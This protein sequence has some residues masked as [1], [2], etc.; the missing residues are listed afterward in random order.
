MQDILQETQFKHVERTIG[1]MLA[2]LQT[3]SRDTKE[4]L[5]SGESMEVSHFVCSIMGLCI[6]VL[7]S[8][9]QF[10]LHLKPVHILFSK[11]QYNQQ[12]KLPGSRLKHLLASQT[13]D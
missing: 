5:F 6:L 1:N 2:L 11:V 12:L 8:S 7:G 3:G 9:W 4:L 10:T 13:K